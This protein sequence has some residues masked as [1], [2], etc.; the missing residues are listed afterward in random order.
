[1]EDAIKL[2]PE[3]RRRTPGF[4]LTPLADVMFQ[5]LVFFMLAS[6]FAP[7]SILTLQAGGSDDAGAISAPAGG[8]VYHLSRGHMR[9]GSET[10]PLEAFAA[11]LGTTAQPGSATV[12]TA[13]SATA[14]DIATALEILTLAKISSISLVHRSVV[15]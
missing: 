8:P 14:Q 3:P 12:M 11:W 7:Y 15:P 5:L 1:M 13:P 4:V 6:S 10:M 2:R 9:A